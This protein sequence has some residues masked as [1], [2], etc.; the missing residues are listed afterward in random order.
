MTGGIYTIT[1]PSGKQ[2]VGSA[3]SFSKRWSRHRKDLEKGI[4]SNFKLQKSF[5]KYGME[6]LRFEILMICGPERLLDLEQ[7]AIDTLRPKHNILLV[8][9]S[10]LGTRQ[11]EETKAKRSAAL[12]GRVVSAETRAKISKALSGRCRPDLACI[13]SG[14]R[15][16]EEQKARMSAARRAATTN[17][18][19]EKVSKAALAAWKNGVYKNRVSKQRKEVCYV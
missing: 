7:I 2:Y 19:R 18:T 13:N 16:T 5:N 4:H 8:A 11:S 14:K 10:P 1:T 6:G 17:E 9:G 3:V 15:R 12:K